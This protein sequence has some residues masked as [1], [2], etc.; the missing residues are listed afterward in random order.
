M[1][2]TQANW[3][4]VVCVC[5]C[6]SHYVH[7][8][9]TYNKY[10]IRHSLRSMFDSF[11]Q[12]GDYFIDVASPFFFKSVTPPSVHLSRRVV[13]IGLEIPSPPAK[14]WWRN[15]DFG[16]E[17]HLFFGCSLFQGSAS[18]MPGPVMSTAPRCSL[19]KRNVHERDATSATPTFNGKVVAFPELGITKC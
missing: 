7:L 13:A 15:L 8:R 10:S 18:E 19:L 1:D 9:T 5:V 17:I 16:T 4:T 6:V 12:Y 3:P 11:S 2:V 14:L